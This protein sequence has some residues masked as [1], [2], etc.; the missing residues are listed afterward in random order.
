MNEGMKWHEE[1]SPSPVGRAQGR[2]SKVM[3]IL[4]KRR[5]GNVGLEVSENRKIN[6]RIKHRINKKV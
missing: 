3:V 1:G 5:R 2:G 4:W 6:I